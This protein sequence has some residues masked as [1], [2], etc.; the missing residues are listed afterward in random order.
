MFNKSDNTF[1]FRVPYSSISCATVM[2]A[3]QMTPVGKQDFLKVSMN[4]YEYSLLPVII[5]LTSLGQ[6]IQLRIKDNYLP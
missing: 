3:V 2:A 1:P 4:K 6:K 5:V